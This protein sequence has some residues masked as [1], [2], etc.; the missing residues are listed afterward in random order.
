MK[1]FIRVLILLVICTL[2]ACMLFPFIEW[3]WNSFLGQND[4]PTRVFKRVWMIVV[5]LGLIL[6][7]QALG[8]RHPRDVGYA[9]QGGWL[10]N[11]ILGLAVSWLFLISLTTGYYLFNV[12]YFEEL[13]LSKILD[14]LWQAALQG[15]LV[16]LIEEYIFRGLIFFSLARYW[17]WVKAAVICSILFSMLHFLEGGSKDLDNVMNAWWAGFWICGF[18]LYNMTTQFTFF[19]DAFGLFCVGLILCYAAFRTGSLWYSV[20]LHGGWVFFAKF[21]GAL[22]NQNYTYEFWIGGSRMI[23]GVIPVVAMFVIFPVTMLLLKKRCLSR[24]TNPLQTN[25]D[26]SMNG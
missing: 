11:L 1:T 16:G 5:L 23:N 14:R 13:S 10:K 20:G 6:D 19:P 8:F 25:H 18:F 12:Y 22:F 3:F 4:E 15:M 26:T 7:R 9:L 21:Q 24:H 17:G 2:V